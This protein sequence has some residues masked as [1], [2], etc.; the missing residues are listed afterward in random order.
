M[1]KTGF[2]LIKN[3]F[4]IMITDYYTMLTMILADAQRKFMAEIYVEHPKK[5]I[6][7]LPSSAQKKE[8][9]F[10]H[11]IHDLPNIFRK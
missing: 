3:D 5:W 2:T 11:K 4:M 7:L 10:L 9:S 6:C 8:P 1:I